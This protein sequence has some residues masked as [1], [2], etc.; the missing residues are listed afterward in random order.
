MDRLRRTVVVGL[1]TVVLLCLIVMLAGPRTVREHNDLTVIGV[2]DLS[3][4]VKRFACLGACA[5]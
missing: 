3:G 5:R 2:V 4:S 1:R